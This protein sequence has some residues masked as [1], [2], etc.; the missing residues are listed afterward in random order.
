MAKSMSKQIVIDFTNAVTSNFKLGNTA[1][2][3]VIYARTLHYWQ[4]ATNCFPPTAGI[5]PYPHCGMSWRYSRPLRSRLLRTASVYLQTLSLQLPS[6]FCLH[7]VC[8]RFRHCP[9]L[10]TSLTFTDNVA[11]EKLYDIDIAIA[12]LRRL[13]S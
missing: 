5:L 9:C 7:Q 13:F 10:Q 8:E 6:A 12:L 2:K 11:S 4:K 1:H 3:F